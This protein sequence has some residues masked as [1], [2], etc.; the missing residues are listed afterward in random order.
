MR[1]LKREGWQLSCG[2]WNIQKPWNSC[3]QVRQGSLHVT[4]VLVVNV[5]LGLDAVT[6][7]NRPTHY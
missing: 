4:Q 1:D 5:K 7:A 2:E 6:L 3:F